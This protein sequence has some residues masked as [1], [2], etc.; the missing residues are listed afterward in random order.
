MTAQLAS[1]RGAAV[2]AVLLLGVCATA[3]A[4]PADS[5]FAAIQ[6]KFKPGDTIAVVDR[7][8]RE[9]AGTLTRASPEGLVLVAAGVT[10]EIA[11]TDIG[12]IETSG[13]PIWDGA[14]KG[15]VFGAPMWGLG[16]AF[17]CDDASS[18]G[19]AAGSLAS[20]AEWVVPAMIIDRVHKGR[21]PAYTAKRWPKN[22]PVATVADLWL[23]IRS[24]DTIYITDR[25]SL[26]TAGVFQELSDSSVVL[27]VG[28]RRRAIPFSDVARVARRGDSLKNGA[29]I[30]AAV[31]FAAGLGMSNCDGC[32]PT[33]GDRFALA[34]VEAGLWSAIGM[35]IDAL[36]TGRT[37]VYRPGDSRSTTFRLAPLIGSR[38]RGVLLSI[39]F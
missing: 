21:T 22:A 27:L 1:A 19:C 6:S 25:A 38:R 18:A 16:A 35:G 17:I 23:T 4:Q 37:V 3:R 10:Y 28:G 8:G 13:D 33:T 36:R 30:G 39:G 15:L 7:R 20:A 34:V 32:S 29:M 2:L 9:F 31:G 14:L 5:S 12:R 11:A 24:G 26:E